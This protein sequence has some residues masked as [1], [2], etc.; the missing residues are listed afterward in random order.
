MLQQT[1]IDQVVPY[2]LRFMK[3][4]PN[5]KALATAPLHDVLIQWEGLGYYARARNM[6]RAAQII[7]ETRAGR[8]PAN[9]DDLLALPGIG[10]YTAAAI[11]SFAFNLDHAVL[12]GNVMRVLSRAFAMSDPIDAQAG[13]G[14]LQDAADRL[15]PHGKAAVFNEAIMELGALVCTPRQPDCAACPLVRVCRGKNEPH[16][17]PVK[18]KKKPVPTVLVGAAVI[19]HKTKPGQVLIAQ[20]NTDEM[21][22]GLWEF[23]GGKLEPEETLEACAER[24]IKEELGMDIAAGE[25]L[26]VVNH[27]YSHF[28]LEMHVFH[29]RHVGGKPK[30]IDCADWRWSRID[31]LRDF[32]FSKADLHVIERL[33]RPS[34]P[35]TP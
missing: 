18:K 11:A 7:H 4:F 20:R 1:R 15:L 31:Q 10:P 34:G 29:A 3:R 16:E 6:H 27:V 26:M 25:K 33:Q 14:C 22:G 32:P 12:N 8:F 9:Y 13:K 28:K 21:L 23:P 5:V 30:A 19:A 24:E 17:Y 35:R 2:Y